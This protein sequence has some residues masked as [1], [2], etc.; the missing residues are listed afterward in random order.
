M[1]WNS[2]IHRGRGDRLMEL[3]TGRVVA[4]ERHSFRH[5]DPILLAAAI[6]LAVIGL[7]AIYSATHQSLAAVHLD[8]GRSGET[9]A[10]VPRAG[11]G[12]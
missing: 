3:A 7:F 2:P 5:I 4:A 11:S 6:G 9:S 12:R 1:A 10:H 8:P